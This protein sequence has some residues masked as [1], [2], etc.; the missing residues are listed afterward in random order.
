MA[1][2]TRILTKKFTKIIK[3]KYKDSIEHI[4]NRKIR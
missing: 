2:K 4:R 1:W 3:R